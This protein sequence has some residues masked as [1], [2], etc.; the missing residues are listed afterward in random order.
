MNVSQTDKS[1]LP[2]NKSK[3]I[4]KDSQKQENQHPFE[5]VKNLWIKAK[6][7]V[8]PIVATT[9]FHLNRNRIK[10]AQRYFYNGTLLIG[11][12]YS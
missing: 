5:T 4:Y 8:A 11:M 1:L 7:S 12:E 9:V 6:S 3:Q 2:N 10:K